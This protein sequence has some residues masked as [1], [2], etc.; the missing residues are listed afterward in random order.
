MWFFSLNQCYGHD[1]GIQAKTMQFE[2]QGGNL[3]ANKI[4]DGTIK[5]T[6]SSHRL[7]FM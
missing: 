3:G 7:P 1:I 6:A 2:V 5:P 4:T